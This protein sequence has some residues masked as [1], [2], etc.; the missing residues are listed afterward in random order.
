MSMKIWQD[1]WYYARA[2]G[3]VPQDIDVEWP[4]ATDKSKIIL[5]MV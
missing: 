3:V 1:D 2:T 5:L 4:R